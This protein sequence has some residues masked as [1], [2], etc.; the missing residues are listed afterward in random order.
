MT[1]TPTRPGSLTARTLPKS[2]RQSTKQAM[3]Q[4]KKHQTSSSDQSDDS[5]SAKQFKIA[6]PAYENQLES[7]LG[8][9]WY[10]FYGKPISVSGRARD[11][12]FLC[13]EKQC[14]YVDNNQGVVLNQGADWRWQDVDCDNGT[15]KWRVLNSDI[16]EEEEVVDEDPPMAWGTPELLESTPRAEVFSNTVVYLME[17][18][19]FSED[20]AYK[21]VFSTSRD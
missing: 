8:R 6:G 15:E 12:M 2:S 5:K 1:R 7:L 19:S 3:A 4:P 14:S 21:I 20:T 18:Y 9:G 11:R 10:Y 17:K 16:F 13:R